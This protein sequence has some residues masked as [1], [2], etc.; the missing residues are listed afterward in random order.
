MPVQLRQ[1]PAAIDLLQLHAAHPERYPCLLESSLA[2]LGSSGWDILFAFPQHRLEGG[3]GDFLWRLDQLWRQQRQD[4]SD[5][6]AELPFR[7]GWFLFLDYELV[8]EIEPI[9]S[10]SLSRPPPSQSVAIRFPAA[11]LQRRGSG[12]LWL[13][14]ETGPQLQRLGRDLDRYGKA[15]EIQPER[16]KVESLIEEEPERF[17]AGVEK[18]QRYIVAGDVFQVNLSR[19]WR[20]RVQA[21]PEQ[22][23]RQLR[24]TNPAPFSGLALTPNQAIISSSPE[25]L[26]EVRDGVVQTRP[27]AGTHPRGA[28]VD[29]DRAL[30]QQLLQHPK[31]QAE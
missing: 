16:V 20:G 17:L 12:E 24:Q 22:I 11:L 4:E 26:V 29:E 2:P 19:R 13:V 27:I 18:I 30:S 6:P 9:L 23:Y 1:L 28:T 7:G 14:A 3:G 15:V 25:R 31:E 8:Y 21:T 5:I 10:R